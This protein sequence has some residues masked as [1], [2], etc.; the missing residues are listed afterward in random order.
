[1][2]PTLS[3][4]ILQ[5][6]W[7]FPHLTRGKAITISIEKLNPEQWPLYKALRLE[8]LERDPQAYGSTLASNSAHPDGYWQNRLAVALVDSSQTILFALSVGRPVGMV[9]AT[10]T[11]EPETVRIISMYVSTD[12]RGQGISRQ[13][14]N[15]AIEELRG[16]GRF[17]TVE[18][19]LN[20]AQ[21]PALG[22][23][24]SLGFEVCGEIFAERSDGSQYDEWKMQRE[25]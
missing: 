3:Q 2:N 25:L 13:L 15:A 17:R 1:M 6:G 23:Y 14:M 7:V 19:D 22:L 9:A 16:L 24:R 4:R 12:Y 20:P 10:P 21:L 8:G 5:I 11:E 18:L